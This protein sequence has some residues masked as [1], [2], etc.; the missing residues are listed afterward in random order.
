[1]NRRISKELKIAYKKTELARGNHAEECTEDAL[2]SMDLKYLRSKKGDKKDLRG[3]D[4]EVWDG[5]SHLLINVKSSYRGIEHLISQNKIYKTF[6]FPL[7][8]RPGDSRETIQKRI[9]LLLKKHK[10]FVKDIQKS[11][12]KDIDEWEDHELWQKWQEI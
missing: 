12:R 5:N 1:M 8:V 11:Q 3:I 7:L 4:F 6:V 10:D 9:R 2:G